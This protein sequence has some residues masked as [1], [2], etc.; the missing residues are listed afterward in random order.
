M[1]EQI[2]IHKHNFQLG[3]FV[4][5][6]GEHQQLYLFCKCGAVEKVVFDYP[7]EIIITEPKMKDYE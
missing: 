7:I 2:K 6:K 3:G 1:S 5:N 4:N